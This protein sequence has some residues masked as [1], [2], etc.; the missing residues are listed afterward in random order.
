[1]REDHPEAVEIQI[2]G[3][4]RKLR[5]SSAAFRIA[6]RKHGVRVPASTL[7]DMSL[8]D[9]GTLVWIGLL[10]T[11]PDLTLD[12]VDEWIDA[13]GF[14]ASTLAVQKAV[15]SFFTAGEPGEGQE[16]GK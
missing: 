8:S 13:E 2:G 7:A 10:P 1:M 5:L 15:V 14:V 12:Q 3:K 6:E 11:D 16:P 9:I 4:K